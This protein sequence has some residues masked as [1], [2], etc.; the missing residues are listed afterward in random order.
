MPSTSELNQETLDALPEDFSVEI[1][2]LSDAAQAQVIDAVQ[3]AA[4]N[5][6]VADLDVDHTI[7]DAQTADAGRQDVEALH[8]QQADAASSGD[9]DHAHDL[10]QQAGYELREV[11]DH[12]GDAEHQIVQADRDVSNLDVAHV[13]Q[14]T[15]HDNADY[16]GQAYAAG[17]TVHGDMAAESA[18]NHATTAAEH[19]GEADQGGHYGDHAYDSAASTGAET[20]TE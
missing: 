2:G 12:G 18:A 4:A 19:G 15:A 20:T 5:G 7:S 10:A 1:A 3:D 17:D 6:T 16:A 9:F 13:E 11:A 14:Q 8:Q